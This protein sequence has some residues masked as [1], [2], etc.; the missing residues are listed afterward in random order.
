MHWGERVARVAGAGGAT[1]RVF[2]GRLGD[3]AEGQAPP[4]ASWAADP[5]HDVAVFHLDLPAGAS[6]VLPPAA[7]AGVPGDINRVAYVVS[8]GG[9]VSV[10]GRALAGKA[11][12]ELDARLSATVANGGREP[13]EVLVLQGRPI[14]EPVAQHGP[15]VMNTRAEI[16]AAFSEYQQ[17]QFGGWPF[18]EDAVV[19]P[20]DAGRFSTTRGKDGKPVTERPP[21]PTA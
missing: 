8:P 5:A 9:G 18:E 1:A 7:T 19:F 12:V 15:F 6:F 3:A 17:T 10:G 21:P 11:A 16:A 20:R 4:P 2:A 13:V 14:G